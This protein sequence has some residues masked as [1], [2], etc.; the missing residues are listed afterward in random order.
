[1]NKKILLVE[2]NKDDELLATLAFKKISGFDNIIILRDGEE[3][4]NYLFKKGK[5]SEDD[6]K[7]L[8]YLIILDLKLPK[9]SGLE[10]LKQISTNDTV[11]VIPSIVMSSSDEA[12]DIFESYSCG[13]NSYL[14]KPVDYSEFHRIIELISQFWI[15]SNIGPFD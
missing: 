4:L 15:N 10:L 14:R 11:K 12:S 8:P 2:D 6:P 9:L 7:D 5:Y 3:A 13:A 1:M